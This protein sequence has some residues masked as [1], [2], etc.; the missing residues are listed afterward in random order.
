MPSLYMLKD[1][2]VRWRA[3]Y[4]DLNGDQRSKSF[5]TEAEA[6]EY[7]DARNALKGAGLLAAGGR[8]RTMRLDD[9]LTD[10]WAVHVTKLPLS[11]QESY[12][13]HV[14]NYISPML[15]RARMHKLSP[16]LIAH[17]RDQLSDQLADS[18]KALILRVLSSAL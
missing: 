9:W 1:G 13:T 17:F 5:E 10:C 18:T 11:T 8:K 6:R 7:E 14:N 15:G 16:G 12:A 3:T 2:S 4:R